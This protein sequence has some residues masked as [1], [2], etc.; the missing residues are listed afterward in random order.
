M[1]K[2]VTPKQL[3]LTE[4]KTREELLLATAP[5]I[6]TQSPAFKA[7]VGKIEKIE[8]A[9]AAHAVLSSRPD[10]FDWS[11]KNPN[12]VLHYQPATMVYE[13]PNGQI[14]IRQED[15]YGDTENEHYLI[16]DP[17]Q[18]TKLFTRALSLAAEINARGGQ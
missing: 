2:T 13:N 3:E 10:R 4:G 16:I 18:V 7:S 1:N 14:I 15:Q 17:D 5:H 12:V 11:A 6:D 8:L 9:E